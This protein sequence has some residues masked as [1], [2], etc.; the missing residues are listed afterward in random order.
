MATNTKKVLEDDFTQQPQAQTAEDVN[1]QDSR[2]RLWQSLDYSYGRQRENTEKSFNQAI[3]N[4]DNRALSR[5]M[6]RSSYN[7]QT[8]AN[9]DTERAKALTDIDAAQIA[10]YQ[11]RITQLEQQEKEDERWERQFA[12]NREDA[13]WNKDFQ[14]K[15]FDTQSQQ[16]QMSFDA[17][18]ADTA[19]SQAFQTRQYDD[20]R[21]DTA[22][23]QDFS[24][25]QFQAQNDQWREQF[26]YSKMTND[27]QNAFNVIATA[28][29]NGKDVTDALLKQAGISRKDY[30]AMKKGAAKSGGGRGG[31]PPPPPEENPN[32]EPDNDDN[33]FDKEVDRPQWS[34]IWKNI[35]PTK[36]TYD[37]TDLARRRIGTGRTQS[38][39]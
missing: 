26:D 38:S 20:S 11:N 1:A 35:T 27:Q 24:E 4:A 28:A 16:W 15:Q 21:A 23:Q 36:V 2:S 29:T 22:W 19:W 10:D 14:Q 3:S 6:G 33:M 17:D 8:L 34:D 12:A 18:R 32:P 7:M 25:R 9:L 5:G 31:N 30:N 39:K 37:P 13:A